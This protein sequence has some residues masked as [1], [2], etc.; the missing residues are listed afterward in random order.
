MDRGSLFEPENSFGFLNESHCAEPH[1][2]ERAGLDTIFLPVPDY[3]C[4]F[5]VAF[6]WLTT[7]TSIISL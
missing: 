5:L 7:N 6:D 1:E 3:V 2:G 4:L